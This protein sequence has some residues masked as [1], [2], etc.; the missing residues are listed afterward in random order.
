MVRGRFCVK[1][2]GPSRHRLRNTSAVLENFAR[3]PKKT[4]STL[5]A[6]TRN[7]PQG[8]AGRRAR[9]AFFRAAQRIR[10]VAWQ[11]LSDLASVLGEQQRHQ[12]IDRCRWV[13][14][15]RGATFLP[16]ARRAGGQS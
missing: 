13:A 10:L 2:C 3:H 12:L 15:G 14:A 4:F 6:K 9:R 11:R 16:L 7:Q 1:R 5:S 8:Q